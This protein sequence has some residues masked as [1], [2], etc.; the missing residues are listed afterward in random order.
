MTCVNRTAHKAGWRRL[1][2][3]DPTCDNGLQPLPKS[4][5]KHR[6]S[7]LEPSLELFRVNLVV[8]N[9][10]FNS[11]SHPK[12]LTA[13]VGSA[14]GA[15]IKFGSSVAVGLAGFVWRMYD[16]ILLFLTRNIGSRTKW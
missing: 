11:A 12:N 10:N 13:K 1:S 3:A 4:F 16:V 6:E 15:E 7:R 9:T 2:I 8:R 14:I 5:E